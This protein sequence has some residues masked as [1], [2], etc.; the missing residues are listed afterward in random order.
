ML[1]AW[2]MANAIPFFSQL[3]GII[4]A[5][6]G[7]PIAL[8]LPPLFYIVSLR[9]NDIAI[10]VSSMTLLRTLIILGIVLLGT[11][12]FAN[13]NLTVQK[14]Q[15]GGFGKPLHATRQPRGRDWNFPK[16]ISQFT[17]FTSLGFC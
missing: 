13:I 3:T 8:V 9:S 15:N 4:G 2:F 11:G 6:V 5:I 1:F 10:G 14:A 12:A 16:F 17:T 7:S